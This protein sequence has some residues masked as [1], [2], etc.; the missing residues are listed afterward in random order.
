MNKNENEEL[1]KK[2]S[3]AP[4]FLNY[5]EYYQEMNKNEWYEFSGLVMDACFNQKYPK[6]DEIKNKRVKWFWLAV[7][8]KIKANNRKYNSI[9]KE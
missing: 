6:Q 7:A 5:Y 9:N 3:F 4:F 1:Q 2:K 8:D